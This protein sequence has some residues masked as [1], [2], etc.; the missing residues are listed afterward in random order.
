MESRTIPAAP[1]DMNA[2]Y[3]QAIRG[4]LDA[5]MRA[6]HYSQIQFCEML[7]ERGL[8]LEQGNLS[9][10]LKGRK[11]IPLSLIVHIC[12]IF[13][14]SLAELVDEN[15]GGATQA[16]AQVPQLYADDLLNHIPSLGDSFITD[17]SAVEFQ[18]YL[19]TYPAH[20]DL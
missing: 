5:L 16:G 6:N 19:Q 12:D 17:P 8:A 20:P 2:K 18:G 3:E 10:M 7:Q 15:F 13:K 4:K 9:S 14:I 11:R 1:S